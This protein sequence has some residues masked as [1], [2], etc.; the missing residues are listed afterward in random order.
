M[1]SLFE[2]TQGTQILISSLTATK[3]TAATAIYLPLQCALKEAQFTAGQKADIDVT[4]LCSEETENVNGLPAASEMSLSGNFYRNAA[5]DALR[6]AYDNDSTYAFKIIF[7]SGNGY[8]FIAE[9]RQHTW[10]VSTSAVVTATFALRL[11]GKPT[12]ITAAR[13]TTNLPATLTVAAGSALTMTV[14]VDGGTAPH[15]YRWL[16]NGAAVSGQTT[17]IFNK[18]SAVA[19]DAAVYACEVT[20]TST[21]AITISSSPCIVTIS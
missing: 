15:T 6:T 9:V 14:A 3:D 12:P 13:F 8:A 7:P 20:D 4:V 16:K 5:Q 19:G 18:A 1:A 17:A 11:K 2:R 21:P 10:A